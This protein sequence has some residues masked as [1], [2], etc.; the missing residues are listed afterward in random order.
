MKE[1]SLK[2]LGLNLTNMNLKITQKSIGLM[3]L[4]VLFFNISVGQIN[5]PSGATVPFG[6]N[7]AYAYGMMPTNLSSSGS[8]GQ[9]SGVATMYN[10]WKTEYI[11]NC[12][13]DKA[14]VRF[15]DPSQTV[16]E[17]VAYSMLLAAYAADKDLFDRLWAF[18]KQHR[19]GNGVM[20]WK[21]SGCNS[22]IG[23]NGATDAELDAAMALIVATVQWP[24]SPTPHNYKTDAVALINAIKNY[25]VNAD[26]TFENGDSWKPACRNPSYQAPAYAKAFK[27]FMA[28][29][30]QN[31][32]AFWTNVANKTENLF[33][34]NAHPTSGLSTNWCTPDGP[35]SPDCSGSGTAPDKFGYDACRAPWRQGVDV[36]WWGS[37]ATG[38]V[39]A[40]VNRQSDFWINKGGATTVQ[41][42]NNM[43]HDGTGSGDYNSAFVGPIGAMA[44]AAT[45]TTAHQNFVNQLYSENIKTSMAN[46]Y[47][48]EILQMIGLFVQTGN[49]WNPYSTI[50]GPTNDLPVVSLSA[51][52]SVCLGTAVTL[53]ASAS[54]P[55]GLISKVEFY[56]GTTLLSTDDSQPYRYNWTPN[57]GGSKTVTA[58]AY[59]NTDASESSEAVTINVITV[60]QPE[61]NSPADFCVGGMVPSWTASASAGNAL[62]WYTSATGGSASTTAPTI[63]NTVG[64]KNVWVSQ[65][66]TSS[67]NCES[68]RKPFTVEGVA[69]PSEPTTTNP[70]AFCEGSEAPSWNVTPNSGNTLVWY[71]SATGGNGSQSEPA[72]PNTPA[73]IKKIWVSQVASSCEGPRKELSVE[74]LSAP[75][76]PSVESPVAY[77]L[78]DTPSQL[79]AIGSNLKWYNEATG[80]SGSSTA[81]TPSTNLAGSTTYYVSQ[82]TGGAC[83]SPRA[84]VVVNV[85]NVL[86]VQ[87]T[88]SNIVIDGTIDAAWDA[89]SGQSF[90]NN[91][92]QGEVSSPN[93]LSG[94]FKLLWDNSYFYVLGE[95][96]DDFKENDSESIYEDDGV[97]VYFD[98]G[99]DKQSTYGS[100]DV[101]YS[102]GWDDTNFSIS[103][104]GNIATDG[105]DFSIV[106]TTDGYV[107]EARFPWA[108]LGGSA[109]PDAIHGFD[110]HVNDDDNGGG[111][112]G[113]LS[114]NAT[115]DNAWQSPALFGDIFLSNEII[116]TLNAYEINEIRTF[117]NPFNNTIQIE[118]ISKETSYYFTDISGRIVQSG[119]TD[120]EI[121]TEFESGVYHLILQTA[122]GN[123]FLKLVKVD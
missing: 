77:N 31:Q 98:Y 63:S 14:R 22:V 118:G 42:G 76:A 61:A 59:D 16:S 70:E 94:T 85:S 91:L 107:F 112:D 18:Y 32:D 89:V 74:V 69:T 66:L 87:N 34:N 96:T 54:D 121:I 52:T 102:F 109:S 84:S 80:G 41:G 37:S 97:E 73:G 3:I 45:T 38:Q 47:F 4:G 13:S 8:Y 60:T 95:I 21:I 104:S 30:G 11:E 10:A 123:K 55:D 100:D 106:S 68:E 26:G 7:T 24:N 122:S 108:T 75:N 56:D 36:L 110:F 65:Q 82:S 86:R 72:I 25:E 33:K 57:T 2:I 43:N 5:T 35:P 120:G 17:G 114:W 46:G 92:I 116:T 58:K 62:R 53:T 111:R 67:P 71:T 93:D 113:K 90:A 1:T 6:T 15:D 9:S 103:G 119:K 27:E 79:S 117:P 23:Q 19:N 83:E 81:P 44:L 64:T 48:T 99:N 105:I 51:N 49:F 28:D 115:E 101:Q 12:G 29:N 39:Q 40:V 20:H 50:S 88:N 78:N